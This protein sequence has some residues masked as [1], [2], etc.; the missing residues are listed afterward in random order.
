MNERRASETGLTKHD[1]PQYLATP[2]PY[3]VEERL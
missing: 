2:L 3:N 1:W